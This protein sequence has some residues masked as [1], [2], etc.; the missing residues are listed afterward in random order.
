MD[1]KKGTAEGL[2]KV[3]EPVRSYFSS[4]PKDFDAIKE[5]LRKLG[6]L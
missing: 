5:I 6:K 3:I 2:I 1:L 4:R